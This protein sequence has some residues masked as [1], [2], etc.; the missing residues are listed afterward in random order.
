MND[1]IKLVKK[2]DNKEIIEEILKNHRLSLKEY[3]MILEKD[4]V[5]KDRTLLLKILTK[6][7]VNASLAFQFFPSLFPMD[8][9]K[10]IKTATTN[11]FVKQMAMQNLA[12]KYEQMQTGERRVIM[13]MI[14]PEFLRMVKEKDA[15]VLSE[16]LKNSRLTET[17]LLTIINR[18]KPSPRF[19][20]ILYADKKWSN[21]ERILFSLISSSYFSKDIIMNSLKKMSKKHLIELSKKPFISQ[22]IKKEI[23]RLI[24][25]KEFS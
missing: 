8:L 15:I 24:S 12:Q 4:F 6:P 3:K 11:I 20:K 17:E 10:I 25:G 14:P 16:I 19:M 21:R 5:R 22:D 2:A 1:I 9:V 23:R 13:R 18:Q 7:E